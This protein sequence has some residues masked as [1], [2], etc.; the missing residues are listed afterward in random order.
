M[1]RPISLLEKNKSALVYILFG[2][3]HNTCQRCCVLVEQYD[4]GHA[5][6]H[7]CC[8]GLSCC[9][10]LCVFY[11]QALGIW[12]QIVAQGCIAL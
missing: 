10:L 4:N 2:G 6:Y 11:Q 9:R 5:Q 1:S 7:G 12:Q 8:C 3:V